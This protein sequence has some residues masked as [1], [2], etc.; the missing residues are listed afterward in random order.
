MRTVLIA[1]IAA[2]GIGLA[3]SAP[4]S[5]APANGVVIKDTAKLTVAEAQQV[6]WHNRRRSHWRWGSRRGW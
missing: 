4:A 1:I 2:A 6:G 5:A 3:A